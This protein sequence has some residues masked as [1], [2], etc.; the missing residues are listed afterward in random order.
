M[1][2]NLRIALRKQRKLVLIFFLTIILPALTLSVFGV[3]AIRSERFQLARQE[4]TD[5]RRAAGIIRSIIQAKIDTIARVLV[6][7]AREPAFVAKDIAAA[8]ESVGK[9]FASDPLAGQAVLL[10][11]GRMASFPLLQVPPEMGSAAR[12]RAAGSLAE[13]IRRAET[14]EFVDKNYRAAATSYQE[15]LALTSNT[16]VQADLLSRRARCL[17]K[18][19][20][21][22]GAARIYARIPTEY[23]DSRTT[24]GLP[25]G[26][27]AR[28]QA[29]ECHIRLG[30]HQEAAKA[31]LEAYRIVLEK[32]APL[33]ENQFKTYASLVEESLD[34]LFAE[35][36]GSE[37]P[38]ATQE[39]Y[40]ILKRERAARTREWE[41]VDV[42]A[43]EIVPEL[44]RRLELSDAY[45]PDPYRISRTIEGRDLLLVAAWIPER[46]GAGPAGV[47]GVRLDADHLSGAGLDEAMAG[48]G[49]DNGAKVVLADLSGRPL[50]GPESPA[51]PP[52]ATDYFAGNFPPWK[53]ELFKASAQGAGILDLRRN[54]YFWT[55]LT[56]V[57]V[58]AFGAFL[59]ART[60]GQEMEILKIKSDFVSSVSHEFKTPLTSIR[61]LME[62]LIDGKVHDPA[63]MGQYF[64]IIAQDADRLT[65][66][67]NNLLDF[68]KI[69]EGRKEYVFAETDVARIAKEQVEAYQKGQLLAGPEIRLEVDGEVPTI[70]ADGEALSRA[71]ANLLGNAVKF[72]PTGKSVRVGLRRDG[73]NVVLEVG[74]E[75][76]GIHAD[77]IGKIFEKFFQ[78]RNARD[79][80]ARGTGLGLTLVKHI[81]EAH[82][83]KVLVESQV[84]QGSKFT[85]V[86][87]IGA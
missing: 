44:E 40:A 26:L 4:E 35:D 68:S 48:A 80:S 21:F 52:L 65:R 23:A 78:G 25:L 43:R 64:G 31:A 62:R 54:F 61:S 37:I 46:A 57:I 72:T 86:L 53:I 12:I 11:R 59:I 51:A 66:L 71:L 9:R 73:E 7:T 16:D 14:L 67:V 74:D 3:R 60:I 77:E 6:E 24:S 47:F 29:V 2:E 20:D 19:E 42:L 81:A 50:T 27:L 84:G 56:L 49:L 87:P 82:G 38:E 33:T 83:G 55:I 1:L 18:A 79:L 22:R 70:R 5:A 85:L 63:K 75:G 58:L 28:L 76:I 15:I 17:Q 39:A 8:H 10:Y 45:S 69:E 13:R 34:S 36:S 41:E 32:P 30:D